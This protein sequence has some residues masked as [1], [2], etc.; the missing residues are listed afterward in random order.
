MT[1]FLLST[2]VVRP[3]SVVAQNRAFKSGA[4]VGPLAVTVT[5]RAGRYV[6]D[7]T[8]A[9]FDVFEAGK[10]QVVSHFAADRVPI[11]FRSTISLT[12]SAVRT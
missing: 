7:L 2:A 10:R 4:E 1:G 12:S 5:D 3:S 9:D 6:P 11:T 8:A